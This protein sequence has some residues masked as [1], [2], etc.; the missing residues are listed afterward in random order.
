MTILGAD[1]DWHRVTDMRYPR[2]MPPGLVVHVAQTTAVF[3]KTSWLASR[4]VS[5]RVVGS[6]ASL[7]VRL[8]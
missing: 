5:G 3:N 8:A 7:R 2:E 1:A 4:S 6:R